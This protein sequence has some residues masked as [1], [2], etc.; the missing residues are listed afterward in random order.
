MDIKIETKG[1]KSPITEQPEHI[2]N[3]TPPACKNPQCAFHDPKVREEFEAVQA[4]CAAEGLIKVVIEGDADE[5]IANCGVGSESVWARPIGDNRAVIGNIP[6]FANNV[7]IDDVV[8]VIGSGFRRKYIRTVEAKTDRIFFKYAKKGAIGEDGKL[9]PDFVKFRKALEEDNV[10]TEGAM[11]GFMVGAFP[12]ENN[13]LE[14]AKLI[15][16]KGK[17]FG[18]KV[19]VC[20]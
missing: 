9:T 12:I 7:S 4:A 13:I 6:F 20:K 15:R 3:V 18:I 19:T 1:N 14:I 16:A 2:D 5:G 17:K 10:K 11:Q 8:E